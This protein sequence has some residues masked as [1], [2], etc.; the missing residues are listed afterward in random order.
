MI[1]CNDFDRIGSVNPRGIPGMMHRNEGSISA[2]NRSH[3]ARPA[4]VYLISSSA[5]RARSA[6]RGVDDPYAFEVRL[7][8]YRG[9]RVQEAPGDGKGQRD[10]QAN[11]GVGPGSIPH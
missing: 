8:M 7:R 4:G 3:S 5:W 10:K 2:P 11:P 9:A 6:R 1:L